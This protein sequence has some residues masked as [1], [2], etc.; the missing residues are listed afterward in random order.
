MPWVAGKTVVITGG[1]SGIG[2]GVAFA[3]AANGGKVVLAG[4]TPGRLDAGVEQ[5]RAAGGEAIGVPTDVG[6]PGA[7]EHLMGRAEETFGGVDG[8]V[9]AAGLGGV[10]GLLEESAEEIEETVR[11]D[12]LGTVY[13]IRAAARR[14]SPGSPD[15][16]RCVFD[17]RFAVLDH[18]GV[19]L[20]QDG[21]DGAVEQH[22]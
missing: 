1:S 11:T 18:A 19:R 13:A 14:M 16:D 17:G 6:D 20:G 4:R 8:L 21:R 7:V 12:F 22:P 2:K 10:H 15:R 5:I 3:M 9:T